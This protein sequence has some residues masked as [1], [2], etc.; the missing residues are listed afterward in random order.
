VALV[1][2]AFYGL[3][4]AVH[5]CQV[6]FGLGAEGGRKVFHV[7]SGSLALALPILF[8]SAWPV[9]VLAAIIVP[10]LLCLR[11]VPRL[12]HTYGGVL[13][14]VERRSYGDLSFP[15]GVVLVFIL[16]LGHPLLYA[17]PVVVLTVSDTAAALVGMRY[18]RTR[19]S[20]GGAQ[21]SVEGSVAFFL[22]ALAPTGLLL[23]LFSSLGPR[24][25]WLLA[26]TVA[27]LL[28]LTEAAAPAGLD[29]L[30]IPVVGYL[31]L[32]ASMTTA[33]RSLSPIVL[34]VGLAGLAVVWLSGVATTV[35]RSA[36]SMSA[37]DA[38][39]PVRGRLWTLR[40]VAMSLAAVLSR[41]RGA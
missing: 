22:L 19:Y 33:A 20:I 8:R 6:R 36:T 12:R 9:L 13:H 24:D 2:A 10:V 23:L 29:N 16:S 17:I 25:A 39:R 4:W 26:A 18:G 37:A 14:D 1:L 32:R 21:K 30:L 31:V 28:T 34:M 15:A 35:G 27:S 40:S 38:R 5:A 7:G 41:Y 11:F 3:L